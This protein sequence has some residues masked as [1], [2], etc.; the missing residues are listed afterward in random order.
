[1][2]VVITARHFKP[3]P[4]LRAHV[5]EKFG[6]L[7]RYLPPES[8][9]IHV[10]LSAERNQKRVEVVA[11]AVRIKQESDDLMSAV[12][13]A[14]DRMKERLAKDHDKR[15]EHKGRMSVRDTSGGRATARRITREPKLKREAHEM[16]EV[17]VEAAAR[18]FAKSKKP[19]MIFVS[20]ET[21]Q[22]NVLYRR[23]DGELGLIEAE[24]QE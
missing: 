7:S 6:R 23:K 5:L 14:F 4:K 12:E 9:G 3:S 18:A 16:E 1:M 8:E 22:V 15:R 24:P 21:G 20:S 13:Q 17:E 10:T 2:D 19:F 11:G